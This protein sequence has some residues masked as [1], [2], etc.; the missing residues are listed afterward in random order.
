MS[1]R[2]TKPTK[3]CGQ[4]RLRSAVHPPSMA[5]ALVF[6]SLDSLE[7]LGACDQ[8]RLWSDCADAQANLRLRWS[9]EYYCRFWRA[10]A[11]MA[12]TKSPTLEPK[13]ATGEPIWNGEQTIH[14]NPKHETS[15]PTTLCTQQL[16]IKNIFSVNI[17]SSTLLVKNHSEIYK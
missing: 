10:L 13:T 8:R 17:R 2:T 3:D 16:Q 15:V 6:P 5:R 11:Q 12:H 4:Q 7:A 9:H 1:Q 14:W